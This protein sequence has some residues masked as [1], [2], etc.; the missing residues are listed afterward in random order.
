VEKLL[1][2]RNFVFKCQDFSQ[3]IK[4][5]SSSDLVYCDPPYIDRHVD[6]YSGWDESNETR[7]FRELLDFQGKFILSAWH[8]N[9]FRENEYVKTLWNNFHVM[10]K[11]HFY[12]VGGKEENRNHVVEALVLNYQMLPIEIA[13]HKSEQLMLLAS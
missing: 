4:E 6:Y 10:T 5:A 12:H 3:T 11:N 8:H 9:D 7:L 13:K 2:T 1:R